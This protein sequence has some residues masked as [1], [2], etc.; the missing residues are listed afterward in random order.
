MISSPGLTSL[1]RLSPVRA[2]VL[3]EEFPSTTIPS[4]GTF[5]PGLLHFSVLLE[6]CVVRAYVHQFA[7]TAPA[8]SDGNTLKQ[9]SD[10]VEQHDCH[11]LA[12]FSQD[13]RADGGYR[14]KKALIKDLMVQDSFPRL[15]QDVISHGEVRD[16]KEKEPHNWIVIQRQ[17][18]Q[19]DKHNCCR[20]DAQQQVLLF[21]IQIF[22]QFSHFYHLLAEPPSRLFT[23][24]SHSHPRRSCSSCALPASLLPALRRP[25]TPPSSSAP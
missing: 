6:V 16:Q 4:I 7:D 24:R 12:V 19:Y 11:A 2:L 1:G 25:R 18:K 13:H 22:C 10:L 3:S 9:L 20:D 14:H 5:S 23:G 15:A 21:F 17:N 8:L